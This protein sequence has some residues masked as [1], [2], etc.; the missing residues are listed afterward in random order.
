MFQ[1]QINVK[2]YKCSR[3][4]K[5]ILLKSN[6]HKVSISRIFLRLNLTKIKSILELHINNL[7]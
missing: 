2:E 5:Y 6:I 3:D 7:F 4:L 1:N